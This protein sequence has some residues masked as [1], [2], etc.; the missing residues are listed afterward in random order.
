MTMIRFILAMALLSDSA[1]YPALADSVNSSS[2]LWSFVKGSGVSGQL[3]VKGPAR[4]LTFASCPAG[5][6]AGNLIYI[7]GGSGAP[8]SVT[9]KATACPAGTRGT[10]TIATGRRHWGNWSAASSTAGI[11]EAVTALSAAGGTVLVGPGM[12]EVHS[13]I[14]L[15]SNITLRGAGIDTT[16]ILVPRDEFNNSPPWQFG[17]N[18]SGTV[19]FGPPG[20]SGMTVTGLTVKF[21]RQ[22]SP[23]NDSY[24]VLLVDVANS[25]ID[26]VAVRDG[27]ILRKGNTFLPFAVLGLSSND[28][29][30]NSLVYN[31]PCSISSEG[32]GGFMD[33]AKSSRF[34][35]NYVSNGCNS[36]FVTGGSDTLFEGNVFELANSTMLPQAQAFAAD[37]SS[38]ARFVNNRC[39]GNGTAPACFSAVTDIKKPDTTD[40]TFIGNEAR[41]CGQGFQFQSTVATSRGITVEKG[42]VV[43]CT[44]PLSLTGIIDGFSI[45]GVAGVRDLR[46]SRIVSIPVNSEFLHDVPTVGADVIWMTGAARDYA[47]GGFKEGSIQRQVRIV[48]AAGHAM[49]LTGNDLKSKG[50][51]RICTSTGSETVSPPESLVT[52]A[53]STP[54]RCWAV[55]GAIVSAADR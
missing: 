25:L 31:Q 36:A 30:E 40:S 17:L 45:A 32:A 37:N 26:A 44:E 53:Y 55:S 48:N 23:P 28:T 14:T 34:L 18:P 16:T 52:L 27:P 46:G 2:Y 11:Q 19:I 20:N 8:E 51:N 54:G 33:G 43:N 15:R 13:R 41:N 38:G 24:A 3:F 49:R 7:S 1:A 47:V 4:I 10:V 22:S 39:V 50:E 6:A 9:I 35:H 5:L 42:S 12:F 29:V 21:S